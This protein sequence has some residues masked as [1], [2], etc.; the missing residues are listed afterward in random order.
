[1]LR[2]MRVL[3]VLL[4]VAAACTA[5]TS[6]QCRE[7]CA[8]QNECEATALNEPAGAAETG[9]DESEC[10]AACAA[11]ERDQAT[12]ALVAAHVDCVHKAQTC[13]DILA[14]P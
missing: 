12:I 8:R 11:L 10:I 5:P 2:A 1:M 6:K 14:C 4:L 7:V 3:A 9:F 13:P